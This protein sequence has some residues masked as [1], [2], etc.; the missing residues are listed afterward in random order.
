MMR[1]ALFFLTAL[2]VLTS[3]EQIRSSWHSHDL[4]IA[5]VGSEVLY[6]SD[7]KGLIPQG[8]SPQDSSVMVEQYVRSWALGRLMLRKAEE[9]LPKNEKDVSEQ[10][11][12]Y[13]RELLAFRYEKYYVEEKLNTQVSEEEMLSYYQE[14]ENS[15]I[16]PYSVVKA[17]VITI[18]T[19]SPYFD[20]I[21]NTYMVTD[22]SGI[23]E[24]EE[25]CYTSAEKY[26]NF[27]GAWVPASA[28]AKELRMDVGTCESLIA[29]GCSIVREEGIFT[30]FAFIESRVEPDRVSPF[31]YNKGRISESIISKRKQELLN[32]LERDLL[33][34]AKDNKILKIYEN[35]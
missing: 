21:K 15:F 4:R 27:G 29:K 1:R 24:L 20:M 31:E 7:L 5:K 2:L 22:R 26:N 3:C 6:E 16:F 14:N 28:L 8:A 33:I 10:I 23:E 34:E 9:K 11:E 19:K 30:L 17:R 25:V 32:K 35:E 13:R 18:L 12:Q